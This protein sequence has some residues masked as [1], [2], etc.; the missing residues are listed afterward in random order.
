[1]KLLYTHDN[2]LLVNNARNIVEN[3]G[4]DVLLKNEFAAGGAGDLAPIDTWVEL[5]VKNEKDYEKANEIIQSSILKPQGD[6]WFCGHCAEK[7]DASFEICW[8]CQHE[9]P[10]N[11]N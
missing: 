10:T 6:D 2:A 7:N 9:D 11:S 8:N 3:A 5:W 4:I 1:M